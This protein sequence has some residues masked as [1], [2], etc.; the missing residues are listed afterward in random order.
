MRRLA[1]LIA[2]SVFPLKSDLLP[3]RR[4]EVARGLALRSMGT[5]SCTCIRG[6]RRLPAR[7][8]KGWSTDQSSNL[9]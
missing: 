1:I 7:F 4:H 5:R 3:V 9:L 8:A 6:R 2:L